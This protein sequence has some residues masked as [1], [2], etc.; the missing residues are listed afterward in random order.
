M[1][2]YYFVALFLSFLTVNMLISEVHHLIITPIEFEEAAEELRDYFYSGYDIEREIYEIEEII[3]GSGDPSEA[4]YNYLEEY[5]SNPEVDMEGSSVLLLGCG[6]TDW[7][8]GSDRNR[9]PVFE[10]YSFFSDSKFTDFDGDNREDVSIGRI[11]A[12]NLAELENYLD[13]YISYMDN[14]ESGLWQRSLLFTADD[15]IKSGQIEGSSPS[16]GLNHSR[17]SDD[18]MGS[19]E[20]PY[21]Y[22]QVYG[23]DYEVD[24]AGHKPE[25]TADIIENLNAGVNL[26]TYIGHSSWTM[27][28]DE[29]YFSEENISELT[30]YDRRGFMF[31]SGCN[32]GDFGNQSACLAEQLMFNESGGIIGGLF[33]GADMSPTSNLLLGEFLLP[34]LYDENMNWG[35]AFKTSQYLS[36]ASILNTIKY[37]LLGDPL[38]MIINGEAGELNPD[39]EI[40]LL[41]PGEDVLLGWNCG[42]GYE[43]VLFGIQEASAYIEYSNTMNDLTYEYNRYRPGNLVFSDIASVTGGRAEILA[44]IPLETVEGEDGRIICSTQNN[45]GATVTMFSELIQVGN[46]SGEDSDIVPSNAVQLSNYPNPFN[47]RTMIRYYLPESGNMELIVYNIKGERVRNIL[48]DYSEEGWHEM[49]W[50]GRNEQGASTTSGVYILRLRSGAGEINRKI[51]QLK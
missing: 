17:V 45:D 15:E 27:L 2:K 22:Q 49:E 32:T 6:T 36:E 3:S 34:L 31:M 23:I 38:G 42:T 30:N 39:P 24:D 44:S 50:D 8:S 11:P 40:E 5:F 20:N 28:G 41:M 21:L 16:S 14:T 48:N 47:P 26:W 29:Y 37:N 46:N 12:S 4:L 18:L 43:E 13:N 9:I 10:F 25:A 35:E 33:P 19:I 7:Y 51:S 1:K